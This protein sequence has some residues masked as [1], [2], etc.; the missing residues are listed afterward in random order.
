MS[1]AI[2]LI[3]ST[4]YWRKLLCRNP[5]DGGGESYFS[6]KISNLA[7]VP[8]ELI[9]L[10]SFLSLWQILIQFV[11]NNCLQSPVVTVGQMY[12]SG[13]VVE[14]RNHWKCRLGLLQHVNCCQRICYPHCSE[15]GEINYSLT[16]THRCQTN[17]K[18]W[19][20]IYPA[21]KNASW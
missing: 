16:S 18:P 20:R 2:L 12:D 21:L 14:L 11:W 7:A 10:F 4:L 3:E 1:I 9:I 5:Q 8:I 13:A 15:A 19:A 17:M 6:V